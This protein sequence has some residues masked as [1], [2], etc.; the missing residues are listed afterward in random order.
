[1]TPSA[2]VLDQLLRQLTRK[3]H[4]RSTTLHTTQGTNTDTTREGL[5]AVK[6]ALNAETPSLTLSVADFEGTTAPD[7][8]WIVEDMIPDRQVTLFTGDGGTGKSLI[9]MQLATAVALRE[10]KPLQTWLGR[11]VISGSALYFGAEDE[12]DEMHRRLEGIVAAEKCSFHNLSQ[13]RICSLA[14]E[15]ALL[16]VEGATHGPFLRHPSTTG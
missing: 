14:G 3:G 9:A 6:G 16:A 7:R 4:S 1:M 2:W 8:K 10:K 5:G 13:L 15:D 12:Q 11:P